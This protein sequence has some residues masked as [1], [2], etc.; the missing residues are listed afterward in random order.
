MIKSESVQSLWIQPYWPRS[1]IGVTRKG[2]TDSK[3][4]LIPAR[5]IPWC[6]GLL[7]N[8]KNKKKIRYKGNHICSF[9]FK[10]SRIIIKN[11]G[12]THVTDHLAELIL[13]K[14]IKKTNL[15]FCWSFTLCPSQIMFLFSQSLSL[16]WVSTSS[17]LRMICVVIFSLQGTSLYKHSPWGS[18][19]KIWNKMLCIFKQ[20]Y[21]YVALQA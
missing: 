21:F 9:H 17:L 10:V 11:H 5:Y 20:D 18:S 4:K 13:G 14:V 3:S 6:V 19:E 16:L 12:G 8:R 15:S 2:R 1:Q 7:L